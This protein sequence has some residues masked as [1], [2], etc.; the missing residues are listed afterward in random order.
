MKTNIK[1]LISGNSD[2]VNILL[3][4]SIREVNVPST[5][6]TLFKLYTN[7]GRLAN[8]SNGI[9]SEPATMVR[10]VTRTGQNTYGVDENSY[11]MD[12]LNNEKN[13]NGIYVVSKEI[14]Y[15]IVFKVSLVQKTY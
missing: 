8:L 2:P 6:S 15:E 12:M 14:Q 4:N 7:L 10:E 5:N 11:Q 9:I 13:S 3:S 1:F